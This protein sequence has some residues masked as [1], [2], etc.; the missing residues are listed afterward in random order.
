MISRSWPTPRLIPGDP[1]LRHLIVDH[2]ARRDLGLLP[3]VRRLP[4]PAPGP[5]GARPDRHRRGDADLRRAARR[6]PDPGTARR[7]RRQR[8]VGLLRFCRMPGAEIESGL[9]SLVLTGEQSNTSL[10]FGE[11]AIFKVFR[12]VSPG[13][14][15]RPGGRLGAG[16]AGLVAHRR[17]V[18]LGRDPDGRRDHRAGASCRGTCGPPRT[19]GRSPRPACA[20]CTPPPTAP[21]RTRPAATSAARPSGSAR[22]PRRSTATWRRV[23]ASELEPEASAEL[24][25]QMSGGS[26]WP[27]PRCPSCA[28]TPTGSAA[29]TRTWPS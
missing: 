13:T 11:S 23:R 14:E 17:A 29:R 8:T 7:D 4:R 2:L 21:A 24:A 6:G 26:T 12:R 5:A 9:D 25:E 22:P 27:S 20:T 10:V 15:P 1:G 16:P 28:R 18:R 19:A 3:A